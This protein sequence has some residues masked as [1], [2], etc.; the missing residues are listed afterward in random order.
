MDTFFSAWKEYD[1]SI[2]TELEQI[3]GKILIDELE[4][5]PDLALNYT[6]EGKKEE[7]PADILYNLLNNAGD[8]LSIDELFEQICVTLP[9]KYKSS[10]SLRA[11]ITRDPRLCLLGVNNMVALSEWELKIFPDTMY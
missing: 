9:N 6:L 7:D 3:V 1:F 4:L 5:I 8:P 2:Q 10:N 11:I